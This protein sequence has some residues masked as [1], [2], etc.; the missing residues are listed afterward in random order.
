MD[1]SVAGINFI[2]I[3]I[4]LFIG[5]SLI[6]RDANYFLYAICLLCTLFS[7]FWTFVTFVYTESWLVCGARCLEVT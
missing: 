1:A 2:C 5:I 3:M 7:V 6:E 4:G